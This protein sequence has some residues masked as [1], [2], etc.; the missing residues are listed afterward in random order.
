MKIIKSIK[1]SAIL[2]L[3]LLLAISTA[4]VTLPAV[5]AQEYTEKTTYAYI[6][7]TPNP[8]GVGQEVLL[9]VG[10][11][12]YLEVATDGWE[13]L[14][15]TVTDPLGDVTVLGPYRS[16]STGGTGAVFVPTMV[17]TYT[18]QTSFPE[19]EY[20]WT[21]GGR[22]PLGGG[23][24]LY[25]A[26]TSD[27]LELVVQDE[28]ITYYQAN[29]LPNEYW[30]RPIDA[31]LR[32]WWTIAGS[33]L[34]G[35]GRGGV[36]MPYNDGPET[37]HI[38]WTTALTMG[39]LVGGDMG[40][41]GMVCGDAYEGKYI[42]AL[43]INGILYYNKFEAQ[44]GNDVDQVVVAMD[45]HTGET[46]WENTLLE[47]EQIEFGQ[48]MYWDTMNSHGVY[49]YL[50]ATSGTT[51]M[52][53]DA[54]TGRWVYNI[55]DVPSGTRT[56]GPNGEILIYSIRNG[57]LTK[58]NSTAVYY[59]T[60]L[61][62]TDNYYYY[63]G[64]WRPQGRT[65]D[66]SYGIDLTVTLPDGFPSS[67]SA[68][69]VDD[70]ILG[71]TSTTTKVTS[72]AV[73]LEPGNEGT[74]LFEKTWT[75]PSEWDTGDVTISFATGSPDDGA[76]ALWVQQMRKFYV[77]DIDTGEYRWTSESQHYMDYYAGTNYVMAYGNLYS[78][79]YAGIVYCYDLS[80]GTIEWTY[81]ADDP[82]HEILW[83]NNWPLRIQFV[84]DGR[85]YIG[86][87][88]HSSVDPKPRGAPYFC[89]DCNTGEEV[90]R[91]DG[92][93]R[94]THWGGNSIIGDG[95]IA[96]M[97]TYD[98]RIYAIGKGPSALTVESPKSGITAGSMVT[99]TGT[100]MDISPGTQSS[101]IAMR[102]PSGVPAI[103]D[104][105]MSAWMMYVYKQFER[106]AN[107]NGVPVKIEIVD[108]NGEY[109]W[110]GTA[111]TDVYGN[112]GYSFRPQ[113][114]GQYMI[115]ATFEGSA[116]YYGSTSTTYFGVDSSLT[117]ATP[118]EP[119]QP[120]DPEI[121]VDSEK[122]AA[123]FITTEVAIIAAVAV[124]AVIGVAAYWFLKLK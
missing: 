57:V 121:P 67:A 32:E 35:S 82:L 45:L 5:S 38:L 66:A 69:Y 103:A 44:G 22:A 109:A 85:I 40:E 55:T 28:Q 118:I 110:I 116:S 41:Y 62:E 29:S 92:A 56:F 94:Q 111:T 122:P 106:P 81:V 10:I 65:F 104:E 25:L 2:S 115:I 88:E 48:T 119:E 123:S 91:I 70:R 95:I 54:Q 99:L 113:V 97:D 86:M 100:V 117:P 120:V 13:G 102:F 18:L 50:W 1:N 7:A 60:L 105:D 49:T 89:L 11:T 19:Q 68:I 87:E 76:Y 108:P 61:E 24:L 46:L 90:W 101:E 84:T 80:T 83:G 58:W 52:A 3:I 31:Q 27:V 79:G 42:D 47:N 93:F 12:D 107:I 36:V 39:G 64:R 20:T 77:F 53:F 33:W 63:A 37:A 8:V 72:I 124:A 96:T 73:S 23:D 114:E 26:S 74:V 51:W 14:T 98:Q 34:E 112:Y 30:S 59:N 78:V 4:V 15:V 75:P 6:G 71:V 17:G 16:D 43:I 21:P 9:H